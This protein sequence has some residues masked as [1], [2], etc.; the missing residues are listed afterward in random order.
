[1]PDPT[2]FAELYALYT[3]CSSALDAHDFAAFVACFASECSYSIHS[4]E[5]VDRGW[6]IAFVSCTSRGMLEDRVSAVQKSSFIVPRIQRRI[7]SGVR[8][9][10]SEPLRSEA[11]FAVFETFEGQTT[12]LFVVGRFEDTLCR[13]GGVLK[14]K[15][16]RCI[17]DSS[18]VPNSLPYPL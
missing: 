18:I 1:M 2:L 5:N 6:P 9:V 15:D 12:T 13:E 8:L 16:R 4:K 17:L 10:G 11:S 7:V 3:A 14:L